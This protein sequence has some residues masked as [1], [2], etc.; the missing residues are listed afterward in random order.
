MSKNFALLENVGRNAE[1]N[2]V[3]YVRQG[4]STCVRLRKID[5]ETGVTEKVSIIQVIVI[6]IVEGNDKSSFHLLSISFHLILLPPWEL[7]ILIIP[8]SEVRKMRQG[9]SEKVVE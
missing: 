3:F 6:M 8:I 7:G 5:Y 9:T 4:L 1:R 2:K